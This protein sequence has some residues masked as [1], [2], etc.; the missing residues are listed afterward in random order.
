MVE[1]THDGQFY[2]A[3]P[4]GGGA[5]RP[6]GGPVAVGTFSYAMSEQSVACAR[7]PT[8]R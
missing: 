1:D 2:A 7:P 4:T 8:P 5:V 6:N 3:P